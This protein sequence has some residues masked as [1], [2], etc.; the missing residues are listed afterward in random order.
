MHR[1]DRSYRGCHGV[2]PGLAYCWILDRIDGNRCDI[3]LID[4]YLW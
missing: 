3:R 4:F 2:L 1:T